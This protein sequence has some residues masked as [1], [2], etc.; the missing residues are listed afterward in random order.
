MARWPTPGNWHDKTPA[1]RRA[2][3]EGRD[4]SPGGL[5]SIMAEEEELNR[6]D[7]QDPRLTIMARWGMVL[8]VLAAC[9]IIACG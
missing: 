7:K 6:M 9:I 1:Q 2:W 3:I 8:A 5:R 4:W